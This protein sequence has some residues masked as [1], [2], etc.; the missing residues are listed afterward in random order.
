MAGNGPVGVVLGRCCWQSSYVQNVSEG[1]KSYPE[2]GCCV[3]VGRVMGRPQAC[4]VEGGRKKEGSEK[5][6]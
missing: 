5:A 3:L 6:T 2:L 4:R 1:M